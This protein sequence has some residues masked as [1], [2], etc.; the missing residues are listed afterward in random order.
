MAQAKLEDCKGQVVMF[1][2][3][4]GS[5]PGALRIVI[6]DSAAST[7]M[8]GFDFTRND[9]RT[10]SIAAIKFWRTLDCL[11]IKNVAELPFTVQELISAYQLKGKVATLYNGSLYVL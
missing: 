6:V 4:G 10:F 8:R 7:Y 5:F 3:S 1:P 11:I 9:W 2:Y